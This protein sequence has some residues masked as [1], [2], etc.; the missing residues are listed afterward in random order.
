[1]ALSVSLWTLSPV[2]ASWC[3]SC[4]LLPLCTP[5]YSILLINMGGT[6]QHVSPFSRGIGCGGSTL[7]LKWDRRGPWSCLHLAVPWQI[8]SSFWESVSWNADGNILAH[9]LAVVRKTAELEAFGEL[10]GVMQM[11]SF[12]LKAT[13]QWESIHRNS[14][15]KFVRLFSPPR[16][17]IVNT[18]AAGEE[19]GKGRHTMSYNVSRSVLDKLSTVIFSRKVFSDF[20]KINC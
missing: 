2:K 11:V 15:G 19:K 13:A 3:P 12:V 6:N 9:L 4:S 8:T 18:G 14:P 17:K 1:M 5:A 20:H 16:V 7:I 10:R